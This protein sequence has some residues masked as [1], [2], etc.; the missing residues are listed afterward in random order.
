MKL[1]S[2]GKKKTYAIAEAAEIIKKQIEIAQEKNKSQT[3]A[4]EKRLREE[5][6]QLRR[7]VD[8]F[9]AKPT[10]ELARRSENV[11]ERF[12]SVAAR[13]LENM[14]QDSL[15]QWT[16]SLMNSL[17]GLTQ[18]QM[19]HI[20][21]FFREDFAP[22]AKKMRE[23]EGLLA[24]DNNNDYSRAYA[25]YQ[26]MASAEAK[27]KELESISGELEKRKTLACQRLD[28][29]REKT[30]AEPGSE[31][32]EKAKR[33][34]QET[35]Q[36]IDSFLPVQKLL[37]KYAYAKQLREP[38]IEAYI[39]SP[40]SALLLDKDIEIIGHIS[41]ASKTF[42]ELNEAKKGAIL[43]G[44]EFLFR[45]RKALENSMKEYDKEAKD[46]MEEKERHGRLL[47]EKQRV[48]MS[49]ESELKDAAR[50]MEEAASERKEST[51]EA[52]KSRLEFAALASKLLDADVS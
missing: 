2:F 6:G 4:A 38:L 14:P 24:L 26:K 31:A 17:G 52:I 51:N 50:D 20:N 30:H 44:K 42:S 27:G 28:A 41:E 8:E 9:A 16:G 21:I 37:K 13:Q 47:A 48:I 29:E 40:S 1:F 12:C 25:L 15:I 39:S 22:I 34:V 33:A 36:E 46:Y 45:S 35:R 3:E 43:G 5:L 32:I 49:L 23:I 19:L 11:K 7:I 10:P 18:R